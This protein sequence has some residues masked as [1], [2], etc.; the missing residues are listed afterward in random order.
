MKKKNS[1]QRRIDIA[2]QSWQAQLTAAR[3]P[4]EQR[5]IAERAARQGEG[6][7]LA[8][9][10]LLAAH[11]NSYGLPAY[12]V[13][14]PFECAEC[15]A[16]EVWTAQQQKWWYEVALGNINSTARY[17][18]ACRQARRAQR[19]QTHA[20]HPQVQQQEALRAFASQGPDDQGWATVNAALQSKW[21][22]VR[23]VAIQT[24][25]Q[26][27][28]QTHS[29]DLLAWLRQWIDARHAS[30]ERFYGQSWPAEAARTACKTIARHLRA[31]DMPWLGEWLLGPDAPHP[32][33]WAWVLLRSIP[34]ATLLHA[35]D[36]P[37]HRQALH[38]DAALAPR[39]LQMLICCEKMPPATAATWAQLARHATASPLIAPHTKEHLQWRL[40]WLAERGLIPN[41]PS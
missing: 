27:W 30:G 22:P 11:N 8:D 26:W 14:L 36:T 35:L 25:G 1:K 40:Q 5:Q 20:T 39:L 24:V 32:E 41:R 9:V 12:Y 17:C 16:H 10:A 31:E 23:V 38:E 19:E 7:A 18:R 34:A 3:T 6:V 28:G 29:A 37:A 4:E 2:A 33:S 15:G 21:R 13:D